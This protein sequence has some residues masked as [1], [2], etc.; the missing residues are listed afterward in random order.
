MLKLKFAAPGKHISILCKVGMNPDLRDA[1]F[2]NSGRDMKPLLP[3]LC[4]FAFLSAVTYMT[5]PFENVIKSESAAYGATMD[6][7]STVTGQAMFPDSTGTPVRLTFTNEGDPN[8]IYEVQSDAEGHFYLNNV[9][10]DVNE[11]IQRMRFDASQNYPNP[12]NGQSTI[13]VTTE[14]Y[15]PV[16][17]QEY[18]PKGRLI[19][20]KTLDLTAG[21][22]SIRYDP[23][24]AKG[25]RIVRITS[26]SDKEVIKTLYMGGGNGTGFSESGAGSISRTMAKT[27]GATPY[28]TIDIKS[29]NGESE[30]VTLYSVDLTGPQVDLGI[31]LDEVLNGSNVYV[32]MDE[33]GEK[34]VASGLSSP[35][36][37]SSYKNVS[38]PS[39]VS[40]YSVANGDSIKV[41]SSGDINGTYNGMIEVE[42]EHGTKKQVPL[43]LLLNAMDDL[44]GNV[45]DHQH[46]V[47]RTGILTVDGNEYVVDSEGNFDVQVTPRSSHEVK[48][49]QYENGQPY[50]FIRTVDVPGNQDTNDLEIRVVDYTGFDATTTPEKFKR[51]AGELNFDDQGG[52]K[53]YEGLK[54]FDYDSLVVWVAYDN[55]WT[56]DT[57][58]VEQQERV[59]DRFLNEILPNFLGRGVKDV[60]MEDRNNPEDNPYKGNG[61]RNVALQAPDN[62]IPGDG[63]AAVSDY[64]SDGILDLGGASYRTGGN[65]PNTSVIDEEG[66]T[67]IGAIGI[68]TALTGEQTVFGSPGAATFTI[69]DTKFGHILGEATYLPKE[70]INR[71]LGL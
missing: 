43:E 40:V 66:G 59:R 3:G 9:K 61:S 56:N 13:D 45:K 52:N 42:M 67:S 46:N 71:I 41:A 11:I 10:T 57:F 5:T 26:G 50:S 62:S 19:A 4:L 16:T 15:G 31:V 17:F 28:F 24:G 58:T 23:S 32:S 68:P 54:K 44:R 8:L 14:R 65:L 6:D 12:F 51:F 70:G 1:L 18:D 20:S 36:G 53:A 39:E 69:Y 7:N 63:E 27:S 33:D 60:Y 64:D 21:E 25:A 29:M 34:T 35:T 2:T 48:A 38:L 37:I 47:A 30:P 49:R 22:H 55:N